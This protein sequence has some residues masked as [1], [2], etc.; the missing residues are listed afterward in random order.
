MSAAFLVFFYW[1]MKRQFG[2]QPAEYAT[3]ILA[4]TAW[5]VVFSQVGG[6]DL[7]LAASLGAA[8]LLL[9]PWI[10]EP[11]PESRRLLPAFGALLGLSVLAKGL[12]GPA[13]ASAAVLP[14]VWQRGLR[15]V[16]RD[17]FHPRT[18]APFLA[19]AL[20]WYLLCYLRNGP[21]FLKE[22]F[23]RHHWERIA[24]PSLQHIQPVWFFAPVLLL[25]L[26]PWT[27]L[28]AA[29]PPPEMRKEPRIRFLA[30]WALATFAIFSFATNK[31][32]GYLLPMM[33]ALAA[34]GGLALAARHRKIWLPL[35]TAAALLGLTPIAAAVLPQALADGLREA[36]PPERISLLWLGLTALAVAGVGI[37]SFLEKRRA[38]IALL[39]ASAALNF[40]V[41]KT[42]TLPAISERAGTR[43]LWFEIEPRLAD[44]CIGDVR[45]HVVYGLRYYSRGRLPDCS[46][47]P[48][49]WR[50]ESDPPVLTEPQ[51]KR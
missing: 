44:T 21:E 19:V 12:V 24:D 1:W 45:R 11:S 4:T 37:L 33:P 23:W 42:Q 35:T 15:P 20:P 51:V 27:P 48:R 7:P 8:L 17:L 10:R 50:V 6:F 18:L 2:P 46:V 28:L 43:L 41:L 25:A 29:P 30:A 36:W 5:W 34:L 39:A 38:A 49:P 26:L 22:F 14:V 13:L 16:L 31:L 40:I 32:P 47:E 3:L 9:L